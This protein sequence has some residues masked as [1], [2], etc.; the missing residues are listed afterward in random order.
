MSC[1][2][3]NE[4]TRDGSGQ[5]NRYLKALDP[6]YAPIDDRNIEDLLVYAKRYAS[7]IRFYDTPDSGAVGN[8]PV[9]KISW[10]EFF[11]RDMAVIAASVANWDFMQ[12]KKDYDETRKR[13]DE[14]PK[15]EL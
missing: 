11:R 13:V 15:P 14:N 3:H 6:S 7:Q 12:V 1:H 8:G 4:I 2:C 5:L 10:R 9:E